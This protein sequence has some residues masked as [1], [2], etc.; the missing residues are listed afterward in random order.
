MDFL[1]SKARNTGFVAGLGSGKSFVATLKTIIKKVKAS[2]ATVAYYLPTYGLIRD[3]AFDKFPTML[4]EMGYQYKL[5]KSDKEIHIDGL[6]KIIFR[7]IDNPE[8]IVGYE[9]YYSIIDECDILPL[10]KMT[11]AYNKIL[12]RNREVARVEDE[13]ILADWN[14]DI[15]NEPEGTYYNENINSLCWINQIDVASTPEGFKWFYQRYVKEFNPETDLLV[16]AST[17]ENKHLPEDY[18][19]NLEQQYPPNLLRAY[20]SG[21]FVNLTSGNVYKYFNR[22]KNSAKVEIDDSDVILVG[23]DFN[24]GGNVS[25]LAVE[26]GEVIYVFGEYVGK[27][28]FDNADYIAEEFEDNPEI[29]IYPDATGEKN[30]SN[31]TVS[32]IDILREKD[33]SIYADNINPR[34][35]DRV[36]AV[37]NAFYQ[38]HLWIDIDNC[39]NL[40]DSLERQA[41]DKN[42]NP[43]KSN[44]AG[45]PDDYLDALGYLVNY[46]LPIV[47]PTFDYK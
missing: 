15:G 35:R 32:D 21:Q 5:N 16:R 44:E 24:A 13:K 38:G 3:I 29:E 17:Y 4:S 26:V 7:S 40:V 27:D 43:E 1:N 34:I 46:K 23:Q 14:Y 18:I 42:G 47:R 33:F 30:T 37:N 9:V 12:G 20:L 11:I 45:S 25:I 28:T 41:Y 10:D 31:S 8:T 36:N 2:S 6:G 22:H 19:S 39:P